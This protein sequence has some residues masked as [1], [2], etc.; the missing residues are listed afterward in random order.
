VV[1]YIESFP[2]PVLTARLYWQQAVTGA[3]FY[4]AADVSL[5]TAVTVFPEEYVGAPE[6]D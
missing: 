5:P 1:V 3:N 4:A 2:G 6:L